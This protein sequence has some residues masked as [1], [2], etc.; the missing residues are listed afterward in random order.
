MITIRHNFDETK[1]KWL[2]ARYVKAGNIEKHC[3]NSIPGA[4]SKKFS[5]ASNHDLLSQPILVMDEVPEGSYEAIYFCGVLK[6][7]YLHKNAEKNNYRHNVHFAVRPLKGAKDVWDYE[8]WHVEIEGG[9]LEHIPATYELGDKLF[10]GIY[11]SHYYTCRI[12]R[13]MVGHFFP[14]ELRDLTFG[15]D[16][17]VQNITIIEK[18]YKFAE[19]QFDSPAGDGNFNVW[20]SMQNDGEKVAPEVFRND[21][22]KKGLFDRHKFF[23]CCLPEG[24]NYANDELT[25]NLFRIGVNE[26]LDMVAP[27]QERDMLLDPRQGKEAKEK[28][29]R[30]RSFKS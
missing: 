28:T 16:S 22:L 5:G 9:V 1:F 20:V 24:S 19:K 23:E 11:D 6:A 4:Y 18:G 30:P 2:W 26:F 3:V 13:W 12:F 27:Y 15:G 29:Y 21:V 7:G 17:A 10:Q 8:N 25:Y 14:N